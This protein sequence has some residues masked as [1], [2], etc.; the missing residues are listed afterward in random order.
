MQFLVGS[1]A[2][3]ATCRRSAF[4]W[5]FHFLVGPFFYFVLS[6]EVVSF[7]CVWFFFLFVLLFKDREERSFFSF[8]YF[9]VLILFFKL[10]YFPIPCVVFL[11]TF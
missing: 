8:L 3:Y 10:F 6:N 2:M 1:V 11:G 5:A 9:L 4:G 7:A